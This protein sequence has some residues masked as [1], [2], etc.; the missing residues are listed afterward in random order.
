MVELKNAGKFKYIGMCECSAES[1]RRAHAVH[2]ITC[3]QVEYSAFCLAIE[4]PKIKLLETARELGVGVVAYSPLGNG[5]LTGTLRK[6]ED[7]SKPGDL[8]SHLP[9]LK[10]EN[11]EHNVAIVDKITEM[12][13]SKDATT[14]QLALAWLMAQGDDIFAIPGTKSINRLVENLSSLSIA[15]SSQE[16]KEI[17]LLTGQVIGGRLQDATGMAFGDTPP[18]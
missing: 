5:I 6:Q 2:P 15:I 8:R 7:F 18:L 4:S 17:R 14:A 11:L 12:A 3:V 13:K 16:E 9:W 10:E 1:L